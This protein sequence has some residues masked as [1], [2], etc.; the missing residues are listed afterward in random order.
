[1]VLIKLFGGHGPN[2]DDG[3]STEKSLTLPLAPKKPN[4]AP[5]VQILPFTAED[6]LDGVIVKVQPPTEPETQLHHIPCDLV[7]SIDVS[8]SMQAAAPAPSKP[9]E[10]DDEEDSGLSVLDL[11]K[12]AARTIMETLDSSDRLGIVTFSGRSKVSC[13]PITC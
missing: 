12:H 5:L 13:H 9:G 6:D 7:L 1:M 4:P 8:G 10:Q 3:R 2:E 11:V